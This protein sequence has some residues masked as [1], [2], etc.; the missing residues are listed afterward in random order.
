MNFDMVVQRRFLFVSTLIFS[1]A[2]PATAQMSALEGT[3][4]SGGTATSPPTAGSPD[5]DWHVGITPYIWFAGVHGNTGALGHEIGV[6]ASFGDIFS[7]LNIG[8][9]GEVEARKKRVL[10]VSDIMWMRLSD[11]KGIPLNDVGIQSVDA[12]VKQF[13]LTPGVGYRIVDKEKLK[14]DAIVG[15]RYWHLGESLEFTPSLVGGVSA[16]QNWVDVLGGARIHIPLSQKTMITVGGDA[17]G[18]GANSDYQVAGILGY[19]ISKKCVL[20]AGWRYLDVNYRNSSSFVYNTATS[21][22]LLGLTINLK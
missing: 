12:K 18:G 2:T 4:Q 19:K 8:L 20:Q 21:G 9:M 15:L 22:L 13:L 6:H 1:L 7:Y 14:I 5:D 10:L 3:S 17:G 16:S 11:E